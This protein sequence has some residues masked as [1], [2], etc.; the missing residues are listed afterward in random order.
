MQFIQKTIAASLLACVI[1]LAGCGEGTTTN[2]QAN[3]PL[4]QPPAGTQTSIAI[5]NKSDRTYVRA[6]LLDKNGQTIK[7]Q[8]INCKVS[9]TNCMLYLPTQI[10]QAAT[11]LVQ[12]TQRRMVGAYTFPNSGLSSFNNVYP[13]SQSTGRYLA[14]ILIRDYLGKDKISLDEASQ[15]LL[16][17]FKNY[18][19]SEGNTDPFTSLGDYYLEQTGNSSISE[20]EFLEKLAKRLINWDVAKPDELP[21]VKK[22]SSQ[23]LRSNSLNAF[24]ALINGKLELISSAHA[25]TSTA[26]C[27]PALKTFLSITE[28]LAKAIPTAGSAISGAIGIGTKACAGDPSK[29]IMSALT[30]LQTTVTNTNIELGKLANFTYD[31]E[32][33]DKNDLFLRVFQDANKYTNI[34]DDFVLRNGKLKDYFASKGSFS[35]GLDSGG[36]MVKTILNTATVVNNLVNLDKLGSL[37]SYYQA[38]N[39]RCATLVPGRNE[40][41]LAVRSFCNS[42]VMT[43]I[44]FIGGAQS[45]LLPVLKDVY[46]TLALYESKGESLNNFITPTIVTSYAKGYDEVKSAFENKQEDLIADIKTQVGVDSAKTGTFDLYAGL[47]DDL[48]RNLVSRSCAQM[49]ANANNLPNIVGWYS[50]NVSNK[51]DNYIVTECQLIYAD[52]PGHIQLAKARY[53]YE[54]QGTNVNSNDVANVLGV[55]VAKHYVDKLESIN[56]KWT[57][58]SNVKT[59]PTFRSPFLQALNNQAGAGQTNGIVPMKD[60]KPSDYV[61]HYVQVDNFDARIPGENGKGY[62]WI[63]LMDKDRFRY[64]VLLRMLASTSQV[65]GYR[66]TSRQIAAGCIT[67]ECRVET[68]NQEWLTFRRPGQSTYNVDISLRPEGWYQLGPLQ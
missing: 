2:K 18:T 58:E 42:S 40:N 44:A 29:E 34:Y 35:Q 6:L 66:T 17:L 48:K 12:D 19:N 46:E 25:S 9:T 57:V 27:S 33:T 55:P 62:T 64:V 51:N 11:L 31:K 43:N 22:Q 45:A 37:S 1:S 61:L 8:E 10:H 7:E 36:E 67:Y 15:R 49:G 21:K 23:N 68:T 59:T 14:E 41:F 4:N 56:H 20:N 54:N 28:G 3:V 65:D 26:S 16:I 63:S 47:N 53:Y 38:L 30:A 52:L 60:I 39:N 24:N 5:G 50:P 13:T 32:I